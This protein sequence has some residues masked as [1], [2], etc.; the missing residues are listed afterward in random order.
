MAGTLDREMNVGTL[1]GDFMSSITSYE[2]R[3]LAEHIC[4][5]SNTNLLYR[6][7]TSDVWLSLS[8]N[9][10]R[11]RQQF[12]SDV[13]WS[14]SDLAA[15][16]PSRTLKDKDGEIRKLLAQI[17]A[18]SWLSAYLRQSSGLLNHNVLEALTRMGEGEQ[19]LQRA[20]LIP[21]PIQQ[22]TA[23]IWI[24]FG[25]FE[26][27]VPKIVAEAWRRAYDLL[28][29]TPLDFFNEPIDTRALL[30]TILT[31]IGHTKWANSLVQEVDTDLKNEIE[32]AGAVVSSNQYALIRAWT[33][34]GDID[35]ALAV[36]NELTDIGD[37]LLAIC[38]AIEIQFLLSGDVSPVLYQEA[39]AFGGQVTEERPLKKLSE[40][41]PLCGQMNQ[42][43]QT[44]EKE[45]LDNR[46]WI[47]RSGLAFALSRDD[48]A[49]IQV[50][51]TEIYKEIN[52]I[53]NHQNR[54]KASANLVLGNQRDSVGTNLDNL[55]PLIKDDFGNFYQ[56]ID[57]ETISRCALALIL[58]G[59]KELADKA[60]EQAM[61]VDISPDDWDETYSL[62]DF[63]HLFGGT[64]DTSRLKEVLGR[65]E[66]FQDIWQLGEI[67]LSV[68]EAA[69]KTG[70]VEI[71]G[72]ATESLLGITS[73]TDLVAERPNVLGAQAIW[74]RNQANDPHHPK[75]HETIQQALDLLVKDEDDADAI[76]Y[77]A[78]S[79]A[80]NRMPFWAEHVLNYT[81][82]SLHQE[83][84]PNTAARVVGTAAHVA[85][86]LSDRDKLFTLGEI[87][88]SINDEWLQAEALFWLAGWWAYLGEV[89]FSKN[90][91]LEAVALGAWEEINPEIIQQAWTDQNSAHQLLEAADY[92]GWPSTKVAVIFA[93]LAILLSIPQNWHLEFG[94]NAIDLIPEQYSEKRSL[95]LSMIVEAIDKFNNPREELI[96]LYLAVL[97]QAK[98]RHT[99]EFW[100]SL[101]SCLP[102]LI[103]LFGDSIG[104]TIWD[105]INGVNPIN[106]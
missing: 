38:E 57:K 91:F 86:L 2:I 32:N 82:Q 92:I 87:S 100:A 33:S 94:I 49:T 25:A 31:R 13:E 30:A 65:S 76:A 11:S 61:R 18:L 53:S 41:L 26:T 36:A 14:Y 98:N 85:A 9:F 39:L 12:Y 56:L 96:H 93:E 28:R 97:G 84:D 66:K 62:I 6:L 70:N 75:V 101:R 27:N 10:D 67:L 81:V 43:I 77:L 22:A 21:D 73:N 46:I 45:N 1:Y 80:R 105:E 102:D 51:K 40:T 72:D 69:S 5:T 64:K 88:N 3:H 59:E 19:A 90:M 99:G 83:D 106:S 50:T 24:G 55:L 20:S 44:Y 89:K 17:T 103:N 79:L 52:K 95:C 8:M 37:R 42:A 29:R 58:L 15:K 16:I 63:A 68:T 23:L 4:H 60:V 78:L 71:F 104:A 54:L 35:K 48:E 74:Y 7:V 47:L 34:V